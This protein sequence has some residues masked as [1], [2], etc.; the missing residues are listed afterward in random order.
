[1]LYNNDNHY[2]LEGV[3]MKN[4]WLVMIAVVLVLA[5][6]GQT[7]NDKSSDTK[8][9]ELKTAK[10]E[11]E[12][13]IPQNPERIVVL[14]PTYA[15]GLKYL[16]AHIVGV[17]DQIDQSTILAPK[18]K[19]VDKLGAEDVEKVATLKP[20]L[21][22]TY[23]TDK[24]VSKLEKIAPTLAFDYA[25]YDYLEQQEAMGEILNKEKE[26][27]EWKAK[28]EN[29]TE[30]DGKDIQKVIGEDAT[31][32]IFEDFNKKIYAYGKNWGRGSEVIYQAFD[33]EMPEALEKATEKEG[34]TEVSKEAVGKYAGDYIVTAKAKDAALP[35]FQK[36][37]LWQNLEAVQN[38]H[39]FN[40]DAS[41]YW[42][43]DP[44]S[45][46]YIRKDLKEK[47]LSES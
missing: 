30:K 39:T 5:A 36:T 17:S 23:N 14:A 22:I 28:W 2:Q 32:S 20:D 46:D 33:L 42:Y 37:D 4:L 38:N 29:Q 26:V 9:F 1:M 24:N 40:V 25:Q 47:L 15:G 31:V 34:W 16:G 7:S 27:K 10:G 41:I 13:Q 6:C 18:F 35:D 3:K 19:D 11:K 12:V 43:N 45:L 21:I 8:S 44:Y